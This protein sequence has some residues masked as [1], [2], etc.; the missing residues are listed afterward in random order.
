MNLEQVELVLFVSSTGRA[1]WH[2]IAANEVPEWVKKPDVM[3]RLAGG[4]ECM[5]CAEGVAGSCWYRAV[6]VKDI[7]AAMMDATVA[8]KVL[9]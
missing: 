4:E 3:A 8:P 9:N 6:R 5:D 7:H 2:P 1:P